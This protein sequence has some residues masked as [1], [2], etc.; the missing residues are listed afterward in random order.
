M[1]APIAKGGRRP[2]HWKKPGPRPHANP[3]GLTPQLRWYWK[4]QQR[5]LARLR[6]A[7][8]EPRPPHSKSE[9]AQIHALTQTFGKAF[10]VCRSHDLDR[11]PLKYLDAKGN[12][13]VELELS[14]EELIRKWKADQ[15]KIRKSAKLEN[16]H[17][18]AS[19][20]KK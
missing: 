13:R 10:R 12:L 1:P 3:D 14:A 5:V 19:R 20:K 16:A 7:P 2:L 18:R 4:N 9:R 17:G 8:A 15:R 11:P 6:A